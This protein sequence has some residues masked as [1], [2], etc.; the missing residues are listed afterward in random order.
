[1]TARPLRRRLLAAAL[2]MVAAVLVAA[3]GG[4]LW[5]RSRMVASL[6]SLEGTFTLA[7]LGGRVTVE[8]DALGTP[9]VTGANRLDVARA[10]GWLHAQ[11]RF[12]QMD[13][14]RRRGAGE[15]AELFGAAAV[16]LDKE[17]R[18]HGFREL[19]RTVL[20]RT[21]AGRRP[22][23]E[24]YAQGVNAGLAALAARPW[25]YAVLRTAP[26]PWQPED[27]ILVS[28]AMLL[29]L[30]EGTGRYIRNLSEIRDE[31]GPAS[32]AFFA[33]L[34]TPEDAA[35]DGSVGTKPPL[36]P[37]DE[38]DLHRSP[39]AT[40]SLGGAPWP[41][42]QT[43]GS[44]AFAVDGRFT[45]DG[46]ALL[47]NDTHL[48]LGLPNIWYRMAL[49]WP[50]R[51]AIGVTLPGTPFVVAG[52]TGRIAWGFT[53]S[54]TGTGD[55]LMV[56]PSISPA[57]YHGPGGGLLPYVHRTETIAVHGGKPVT[58]DVTLTVWGPVVAVDPQGKQ[59]IYHWTED[60]PAATDSG[61]GDLEEARD[62]REAVAAV[63]GI[64][65]PAQNF[66]AADSQGAIAWT[67]AG[68]LPKR[69]GYD[70]R[71][72]VSWAFGDRRWDGLLPSAEVP[73]IVA[74]PDGRLWTGN[75]RPVGGAALAT[76]GDAGYA[77]SARAHQI[78]GDLE[79]LMAGGH[80]VAPK[81][82]LG[83]QLD[84]RAL[85][86]EPWHDLLVQALGPAA[87]AG[88]PARA[89]LLEAARK[90]EG[91]AATS[92]IGYRVVQEFR[93]AVAHRVLD[94]IFTPC[95]D[96]DPDF[97]WSRLHY[98]GALR[99]LVTERPP[100][101]LDP[102]FASWDDLLAAAAD[103]VAASYAKAGADP[104]TS[105]W[106]QRNTAK[107]EHPFARLLPRWAARF[108]AMPRDPLPGDA[109]MPRV[110]ERS[111]G[112]SERFVVSPGH[113]ETGLFHMPGGPTS[114]P[115]SP[116]FGAGHEAW[117]RGDPTPFLPGPAQHQLV[118]AP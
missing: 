28:Y 29:D 99:T 31:L 8:R 104:R 7:G 97:S 82:F 94:P 103:D 110:A 92:A 65:V 6:P 93:L 15:L 64:G 106:G 75:N 83:I 23:L 112:A 32:L 105:T 43:P 111:F 91:R 22:M 109:N 102:A 52:S 72:P 85:F 63:H 71:L 88:K 51:Q 62:V 107:I 114:N 118:L 5:F 20:A 12:F 44:N 81:D 19:A 48:R 78:R 34:A 41:E 96:R 2:I 33:P 47:A 66:V 86:L 113:E 69:L 3:G 61:I 100:R 24:A 53:N 57:L 30:Q 76:L 37:A 14:L 17:A 54:E 56:D 10:T 13:L 67:I 42:D 16:P 4:A 38:V 87:V 95:T 58:L 89:A 68:R 27:T 1:M 70:G 55:V 46:G 60:D 90:W 77:L 45:A 35:L 101:F 18:L 73:V 59:L 117:V 25:E 108:L 39:P 84:D 11:D 74:P 115:F 9:T 26:R 50:G 40:A 80:K 49:H 21:P 98:E 36:P 79:A 116:Y